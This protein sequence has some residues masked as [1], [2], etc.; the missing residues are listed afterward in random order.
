M[1]S[2]KAPPATTPKAPKDAKAIQA[3]F[4]RVRT[5][6]ANEICGAYLERVDK[7]LQNEGVITK[8]EHQHI[9][10]KIEAFR[11][12]LLASFLNPN[13]DYPLLD[14]VEEESEITIRKHEQH[15]TQAQPTKRMRH[16]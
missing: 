13:K 7:L 2:S 15:S 5:Q 8:K 1:S 12:Q 10:N 6:Y 16:T 14:D 9:T 11:P 3:K 4:V